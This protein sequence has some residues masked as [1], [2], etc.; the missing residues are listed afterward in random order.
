MTLT[1]WLDRRTP[2]PPTTLDRRIRE[3]LQIVPPIDPA[4][5]HAHL[6][7]TAEQVLG[8]LLDDECDSRNSALDLLVA[9]ALMT[10]AF[11]AAADEPSAIDERAHRA[12]H[13]IPRLGR[14]P[15]T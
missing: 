8:R 11:E 2:A 3:V 14:E 9:D 1:A 10:Y 4:D 13:R 5:T 12:M 7:A 6:A 15:V